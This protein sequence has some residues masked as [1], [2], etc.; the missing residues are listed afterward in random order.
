[1][2]QLEYY[3][4]CQI[5]ESKRCYKIRSCGIKKTAYKKIKR[6]IQYLNVSC[7]QYRLSSL[8]FVG[9]EGGGGSKKNN[10]YFKSIT[11]QFCFF[12]CF[13]MFLVWIIFLWDC[14]SK[15]LWQCLWTKFLGAV[16]IRWRTWVC[17]KRIQRHGNRIKKKIWNWWERAIWK[18]KQNEQLRYRTLLGEN[19]EDDSNVP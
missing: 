18:L 7:N 16:W 5:A 10:I 11:K 15:R 2:D 17:W 14:R 4:R 3:S 6:S 9:E 8:I 12:K 19:V 13:K 1:M